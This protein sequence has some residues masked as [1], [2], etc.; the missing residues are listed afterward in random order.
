MTISLAPVPH[1]YPMRIEPRYLE[2][3]W[4]GTALAEHLG[5]PAPT[6]VPIGESWEIFDENSIANGPYAG[7]TIG[8]LRGMMGRALTGQRDPALAFPLLT[9]LIDARAVLSVQVHPDDTFA[10]VHEGQPNGKTECWYILRAEPGAAITYGLTRASSPAEYSARVA[11]GT[12]DALLRSVPVQAGDVFYLPAGTLHAIGAGI[13]LYEVQQSSDL[14]YRIYDWD[15]RDASGQPRA[16]HIDK[17]RRVLDY[18]ACTRTAIQPLHTPSSDLLVA[19][20]Y[21]S[22][23]L[24]TAS[25]TL[26]RPT[27]QSAVVV[28]ALDTALSLETP[29]APETTILVPY[30][31]AL[32]PAAAHTYTVKAVSETARAL[33]ASV[34]DDMHDWAALDAAAWATFQRQCAD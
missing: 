21:F 10:R 7:H 18:R 29:G 17:A 13:I 1:L 3:I 30:S 11:N 12:L 8:Q 6:S 4:G 31:S 22:L 16:L 19:S 27:R 20:R 14:T 32:I 34:P 9:K 23:E 25:P 28:C 26:L 2:R 33:V 15:R 5:K 24:I